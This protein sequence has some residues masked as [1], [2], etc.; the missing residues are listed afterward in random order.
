MRTPGAPRAQCSRRALTASLRFLVAGDGIAELA[1]VLVV[2]F[3]AGAVA[4]SRA[5]TRTEATPLRSRIR[6][7]DLV[8]VGDRIEVLAREVQR[9]AA[10]GAQCVLVGTA[11]DR[12]RADADRALRVF[13][14]ASRIGGRVGGAR[15][16][17]AQRVLRVGSVGAQ[18]QRLAHARE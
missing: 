14:G 8:E 7:D 11:C 5:C 17:E 4:G 13:V 3:R 6:G 10:R 15:E 16:R 2:L 18:A 12:R 1:G 9:D